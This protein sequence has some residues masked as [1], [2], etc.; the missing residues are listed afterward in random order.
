MGYWVRVMRYEVLGIGGLIW[1][2]SNRVW[3]IVNTGTRYG[4]KGIGN[5]VWVIGH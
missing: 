5:E 2:V 4:I 1:D 3:D